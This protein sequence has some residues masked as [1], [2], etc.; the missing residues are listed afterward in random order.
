MWLK[1]DGFDWC[2]VLPTLHDS[3]DVDG[4]EFKICRQFV[5]IACHPHC[6]VAKFDE[7]ALNDAGTLRAIVAF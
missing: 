1:H 5:A 7:A 4:D 2:L 3:R 6:L